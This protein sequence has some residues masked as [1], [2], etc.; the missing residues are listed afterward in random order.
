MAIEALEAPQIVEEAGPQRWKWT[1]EELQRASQ[2]GVFPPETRVELMDGEILKVMR[3]SHRHSR[4]VSRLVRQFWNHCDQQTQLI[5][6]EQPIHLNAHFEPVPDLA[7]I[8]G[9]DDRYEQRFPDPGEV[10][11]IVEV[12]DSSLRY[13][14]GDKY[15]AYAAAGIPEYWIVNLR[16]SQVEVFRQPEGDAYGSTQVYSLGKA[17]LV[18][19][20]PDASIAVAALL[21]QPA[22]AQ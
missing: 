5:Q 6:S 8:Q 18:P 11:L 4:L 20:N 9:P 3:P 1:G 22:E 12:A 21:G 15:R 13:D 2:A 16:E 14:Q 10:F 19:M 17:V 7:I